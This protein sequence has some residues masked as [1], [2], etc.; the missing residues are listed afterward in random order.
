MISLFFG[1]SGNKVSVIRASFFCFLCSLE[2]LQPAVLFKSEVALASAG[3]AWRGGGLRPERAGGR[4]ESAQRSQQGTSLGLDFWLALFT[5][6]T[7]V[8][9]EETA[10]AP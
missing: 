2:W 10:H 4:I 8:L 7:A 3:R 9:A 5:I 6:G 1:G